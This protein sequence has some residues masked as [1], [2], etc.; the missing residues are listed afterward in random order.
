[1]ASIGLI[2]QSASLDITSVAYTLTPLLGVY[3]SASFIIPAFKCRFGR[4]K[5]F[6]P[7]HRACIDSCQAHSPLET[8]RSGA[9]ALYLRR[10]ARLLLR[11][12]TRAPL[13]WAGT[14]AIGQTSGCWV[15]DAGRAEETPTVV[16]RRQLPRH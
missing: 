7:V 10:R 9:D 16:V 2:L 14:P 6:G 15:F 8:P 4:H 1:V 11:T 12:R 3:I 5:S 13:R